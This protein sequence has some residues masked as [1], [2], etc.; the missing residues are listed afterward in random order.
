MFL[1]SFN[2]GV[3]M[4]NIEDSFIKKPHALFHQF[5]NNEQENYIHTL[6]DEI[7]KLSQHLFDIQNNL[8]QW[9]LSQKAF[10]ETA[11]Q[12]G[13]A[14]GMRIENIICKAQSLKLDVLE[15]KNNRFHGTNA[16]DS[17]FLASIAEELKKNI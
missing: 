1:L 5:S 16:N 9:M 17:K 8:A 6:H 13:L 11:I 14:H 2:T 7:A 10:K 3:C 4:C 12:I 15:N